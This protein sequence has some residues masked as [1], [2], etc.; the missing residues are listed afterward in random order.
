LAGSFV[1]TILVAVVIDDLGLIVIAL[2]ILP[3]SYLMAR[4]L[5]NSYAEVDR[6]GPDPSAGAKSRD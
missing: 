3:L 1:L 4:S 6:D 5:R 2:F